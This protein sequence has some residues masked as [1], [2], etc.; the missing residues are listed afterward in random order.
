MNPIT[1]DDLIL[2]RYRD[3]LDAARL[4]DI[5]RELAVS[6]ELR[7]RYAAI[8]HMLAHIDAQPQPQADADLGA[9]LW[10]Q[11]EPRLAQAGVTRA[12]ASWRDR[13]HALVESLRPQRLAWAGAFALA[14]ALGV[15][16]YAGRQSAPAV[17][18]ASSADAT[19]LRV[20]DAYVAAHL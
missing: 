2:F 9:R 14:L 4:A 8:E 13:V 19:A 18:A 7:A 3:G 11:L 6:P 1:D 16:F 17:D 12:R 5:E 20:L 15:G 10:R